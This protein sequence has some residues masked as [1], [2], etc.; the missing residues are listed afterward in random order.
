MLVA[1]WRAITDAA[2]AC[3]AVAGDAGSSDEPTTEMKAARQLAANA[4]EVFLARTRAGPD[5]PLVTLRFLEAIFVR[6]DLRDTLGLERAGALLRCALDELSIRCHEAAWGQPTADPARA[7]LPAAAELAVLDRLTTLLLPPER[8]AVAEGEQEPENNTSSSDDVAA[9]DDAAAVD[10][11]AGDDAWAETWCGE[12]WAD[13]PH[14]ERDLLCRTAGIVR[15]AAAAA[16]ARD[17]AAAAED[18]AGEVVA[19]DEGDTADAAANTN[20]FAVRVS[21]AFYGPYEQTSTEPSFS[22]EMQFVAILATHGGALLDA[23]VASAHKVIQRLPRRRLSGEDATAMQRGHEVLVAALAARGTPEDVTAAYQLLN[24]HKH[25]GLSITGRTIHPLLPLLSVTGDP[26]LFNLVDLCTLYSNNRVDPETLGAMIV[27]CAAEHDH[28]RA[29]ALL[30]LMKEDS[31]GAQQKLPAGAKAALRR[32]KLAEPVP[33][34]WISAA[35]SRE[36]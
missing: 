32:L 20:R 11:A 18:A 36:A 19:R 31:P 5:G 1:I 6:P 10:A 17:G 27:A 23:A 29:K 30:R 22:S 26:R 33:E 24:G 25:Y 14:A 15:V 21:S 2:Q 34:P 12:W 3:Q 8:A 35:P 28:H 9:V 4:T 7:I 16:A 13:M